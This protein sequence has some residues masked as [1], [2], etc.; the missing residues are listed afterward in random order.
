[1][2]TMNNG[3]VLFGARPSARAQEGQ[4]KV[5]FHSGGSGLF[6]AAPAACLCQAIGSRRR[7]ERFSYQRRCQQCGW[8][9]HLLAAACVALAVSRGRGTG[10]SR[11]GIR[12]FLS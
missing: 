3:G 1:M 2:P 7:L 11:S 4:L 10:A 12:Q 9:A 5:R 6:V 8:V